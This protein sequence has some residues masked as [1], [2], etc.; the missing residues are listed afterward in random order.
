MKIKYNSNQVDSI[1]NFSKKIKYEEILDVYEFYRLSSSFVEF[2]CQKYSVEKVIEL[3]KLNPKRE[4][5]FIENCH[6]QNIKIESDF[7]EWKKQFDN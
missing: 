4:K 3:A 6:I 5:S 1:F 7:E 2:I